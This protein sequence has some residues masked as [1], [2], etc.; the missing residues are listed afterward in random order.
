MMMIVHLKTLQWIVL[1]TW[2]F[3]RIQACCKL[4]SG[5][6]V[7]TAKVSPYWAGAEAW[8]PILLQQP[9]PGQMCI[10]LYCLGTKAQG[11]VADSLGRSLPMGLSGIPVWIYGIQKPV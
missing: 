3:A 7:E 8:S 11:N 10:Y 9:G 4:L 2:G 6:G 1:R 5:P